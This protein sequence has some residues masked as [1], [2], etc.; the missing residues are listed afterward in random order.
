MGEQR[1]EGLRPPLAQARD[2]LVAEP[3]LADGV[4]AGLGRPR[5]L[6]AH[7]VLLRAH[8]VGDAVVG[9]PRQKRE[10]RVPAVHHDHE[11]L[12]AH[13]LA[14]SL[15]VAGHEGALVEPAGRDLQPDDLPRDHVVDG[16]QPAERLHLAVL[17]RRAAVCGHGGGVG[18][19]VGRRAVDRQ[20]VHAPEGRGV[21]VGVDLRGVV[22]HEDRQG[23][24]VELL[25]LL[26]V[27]G[28]AYR[29]LHAELLPELAQLDPEGAPL[30]A[31]DALDERVVRHLAAPREVPRAAAAGCGELAAPHEL[32]VPPDSLGRAHGATS[33]LSRPTP[34]SASSRTTRPSGRAPAP[35]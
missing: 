25:A 20:H 28:R 2:A 27:A 21:A 16:G 26:E 8:Q 35:R 3:E 33:S 6:G 4:A 14:G 13:R 32:Q 23:G 10:G 15:H 18:G 29:A 7:E 24:G 1:L 19:D 17:R 11:L 31:D 12:S 9:E 34:A 30:P 5:E 22:A